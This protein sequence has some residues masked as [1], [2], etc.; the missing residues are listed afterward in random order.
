MFVIP[1][2]VR[3]KRKDPEASLS[4]QPSLLDKPQVIEMPGL[5]FK[6]N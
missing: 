3:L 5:N 1:V 2:L 6:N 4:S